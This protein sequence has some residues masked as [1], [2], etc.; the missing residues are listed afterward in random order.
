[1]NSILSFF[2]LDTILLSIIQEILAG[3]LGIVGM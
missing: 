3:L 1:M 2:G